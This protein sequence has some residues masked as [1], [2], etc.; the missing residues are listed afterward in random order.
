MSTPAIT[1]QIM[2]AMETNAGAASV[3]NL[4]LSGMWKRIAV[5]AED[6]ANAT[7]TANSNMLGY[8]RRAA[9]ALD[10]YYNVDGS[11]YNSNEAGYMS[12]MVQALENAQ[13]IFHTGS[14]EYRLLQAVL[15]SYWFKP[16][17]DNTT[18]KADETSITV[19]EV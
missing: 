7:S 1:Y 6:L 19:D 16:T 17:A 11:A 13:N 4:N 5:A 18:I 2:T 9:V 8:M 15:A 3:G 10:L 12:R 14:L